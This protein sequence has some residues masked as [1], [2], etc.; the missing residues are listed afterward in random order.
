M[1]DYWDGRDEVRSYPLGVWVG[2]GW[3]G[4]RQKSKEAFRFLSRTKGSVGQKERKEVSV[5]LR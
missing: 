5:S 2:M 3:W 1:K 4:E